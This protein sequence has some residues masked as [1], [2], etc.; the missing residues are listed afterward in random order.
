MTK[1]VPLEPW[2]IEVLRSNGDINPCTYDENYANYVCQGKGWTLVVDGVVK[3]CA[4]IMPQWK[5]VGEAW[6]LMSRWCNEHPVTLCKSYK[7]KIDKMCAPYKR[8][9][10]C[11]DENFEAAVNF[12]KYLKFTSEGRMLYYGPD[13]KTYIRFARYN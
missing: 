12:A 4:G 2:H 6:A 11:V 10:M 5:G 9:Q 8:V 7:A 3:G 13:G 1:L